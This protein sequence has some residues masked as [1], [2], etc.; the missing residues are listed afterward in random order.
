VPYHPLFNSASNS[1]VYKEA[2][3]GNTWRNNSRRRSSILHFGLFLL[4]CS[5]HCVQKFRQLACF[6]KTALF[7]GGKETKAAETIVNEI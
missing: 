2:M 7:G 6:Q 4:L 5:F 1:G 3:L